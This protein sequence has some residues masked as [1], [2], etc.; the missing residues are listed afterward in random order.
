MRRILLSLL[1][2]SWMGFTPASAESAPG[3]LAPPRSALGGGI[4]YTGIV[5][6]DYQRWVAD[7]TSIEVGL[8]PLLLHN[9]VAVGVTQHIRLAPAA[10]TSDTSIVLTGMWMHIVNMGGIAGGPGAR[11][12][13]EH[14][15]QKFGISLATGPAVALGGEFHGDILVDARLTLWRLKRMPQ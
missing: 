6:I 11:V 4:G 13:V 9:V 10:T 7:R 5:H 15:W 12:G 2:F 8:T 14:L 1:C 3:T